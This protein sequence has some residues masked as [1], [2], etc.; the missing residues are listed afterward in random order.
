MEDE[1]G[2]SPQY[3]IVGDGPARAELE[4]YV[5]DNQLANVEF[6]GQ[7]VDIKPYLSQMDIFIL[8]S[9]SEG[10]G[11]AIIEAMAAGKCVIAS[12]IDGI[13]ELVLNNKTGLLIEPRNSDEIYNKIKWCLDNKK[14]ALAI[15]QIAKQFIM[16]NTDKFDISKGVLKYKYLFDRLMAD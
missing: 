2:L 3:I 10:L 6:V 16:D 11:V 7:K 8:P 1:D 15:G 12:N 5:I 14:E 4:K 13:K 9:L